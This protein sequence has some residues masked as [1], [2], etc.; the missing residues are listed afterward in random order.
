MGNVSARVSF[1]ASTHRYFHV[2]GHEVPGVSFLLR[3]SGRVIDN[4][5]KP[6]DAERG[7]AVHLACLMFL[8]GAWE[9]FPDDEIDK[10]LG[11]FKGFLGATHAKVIAC[12]QIIYCADLDYYGRLDLV[13][14]IPD[15]KRQLIADLKSGSMAE[16][17]RLQTAAYAIGWAE[18]H[19]TSVAAFDLADLYLRPNGYR[20][21]VDAHPSTSLAEWTAIARSKR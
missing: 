15:R 20:F 8:Q 16:W 21:C 3:R 11:H 4:G 2:D 14:E 1:E 6:E 7:T 5:W 19:G 10:Y 17:H 18:E 9:H 13:L 12:E